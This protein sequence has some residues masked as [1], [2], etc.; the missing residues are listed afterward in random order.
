MGLIWLIS[1]N[2]WRG[3]TCNAQEEDDTL[4]CFQCH[5]PEDIVFD[6]DP[7]PLWLRRCV[8]RRAEWIRLYG[9]AGDH[10]GVG[11]GGREVWMVRLDCGHCEVVHSRG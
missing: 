2:L 9:R 10:G 7:V 4:K 1:T 5:C 11:G 6:A 3:L 8:S